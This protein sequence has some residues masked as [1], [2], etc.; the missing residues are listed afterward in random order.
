MKIKKKMKNYLKKTKDEVANAIR[1]SRAIK[2]TEVFILV[3][4]D[5]D[6]RLLR[7]FF[8][9]EQTF[10]EIAHSRENLLG[11][12]ELL[13]NDERLIAIRDRDFDRI[14]S[15]SNPY[16]N[17][18]LS[19]H[20]DIEAMMLNSSALDYLIAEHGQ[21]DKLKKIEDNILDLLIQAG[22]PI[23]YLRLYNEINNL[24]LKFRDLDTSDY[25]KFL[26]VD[27]LKVNL[28]KLIQTLKNKSQKP[29]LDTE[30]VVQDL[31]E[32]YDDLHH[33]LD[34][35]SG[36][37]LATILGI[38]FY[39]LIGSMTG[40]QINRETMEEKLRIA[41]SPSEFMKSQLY[42]DLLAWANQKGLKIFSKRLENL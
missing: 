4:G 18:F 12:V 29:Q 35:C 13:E 8:D 27:D 28:R 16:D 42:Q 20:H 32:L 14:Q 33:D 38:A 3:E 19:D 36:H 39:K 6:M 21:Y 1:L 22:K 2:K 9:E 11:A 26:N 25:K 23:G 41:Y 40:S 17:V 5:T 15:V 31:Q 37:D 7:K 10:I 34:I 24:G 30:Q